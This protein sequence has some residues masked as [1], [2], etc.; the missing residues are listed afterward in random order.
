MELQLHRT[1]LGGKRWGWLTEGGRV[2]S[3]GFSY[4][5]II[6]YLM[7]IDAWWRHRCALCSF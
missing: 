5:C 7:F 6:R 4:T 1:P 2:S 3:S